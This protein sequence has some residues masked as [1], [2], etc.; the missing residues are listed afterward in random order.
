ME[1]GLIV[2]KAVG[3]ALLMYTHHF[4]PKTPPPKGRKDVV[5]VCMAKPHSKSECKRFTQFCVNIPW[6]QFITNCFVSELTIT[7]LEN[8]LHKLP[9][10]TRVIY[11]HSITYYMCMCSKSLVP[12]IFVL[13]GDVKRFLY[14]PRS[15][16]IKSTKRF[17]HM[18][19]VS[20]W[21]Q[22]KLL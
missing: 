20:N 18:R 15:T 10:V 17:E 12:F 21:M 8:D 3:H 22:V 16:K 6:I 11:L 4:K 2:I 9:R 5:H 13:F 19:I 14:L 7:H 1:N